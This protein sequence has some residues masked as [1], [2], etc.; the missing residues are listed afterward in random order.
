MMLKEIF[1]L[2]VSTSFQPKNIF[3]FFLAEGKKIPVPDIIFY[4]FTQ[5]VQL[6]FFPIRLRQVDRGMF[7]IRSGMEGRLCRHFAG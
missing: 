1:P 6:G 3:L 7:L 5:N 4:C 2:P